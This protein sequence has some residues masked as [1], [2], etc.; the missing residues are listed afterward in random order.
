MYQPKLNRWMTS[1][2]PKWEGPVDLLPRMPCTQWLF[3]SSHYVTVN[4]TQQ[5]HLRQSR[6]RR[7]RRRR[8]RSRKELLA[9]SSSRPGSS[10]ARSRSPA[11]GRGLSSSESRRTITASRFWIAYFQISTNICVSGGKWTVSSPPPPIKFDALLNKTDPSHFWRYF[12]AS[13]AG[14]G[15][16]I[17]S[18]PLVRGWGTT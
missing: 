18:A 8:R 6:S 14:A 1:C 17:A 4:R 7:R 12:L 2:L 15:V 10:V 3:V 5:P 9:A 11:P 13:L 16:Q